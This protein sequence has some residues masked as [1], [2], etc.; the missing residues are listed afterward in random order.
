VIFSAHYEKDKLSYISCRS[1]RLMM[2]NHG[3]L[4]WYLSLLMHWGSSWFPKLP[5]IFFLWLGHGL[6]L[7]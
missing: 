7:Q 2:W 5:G 1:L 3:N 6:G 4:F